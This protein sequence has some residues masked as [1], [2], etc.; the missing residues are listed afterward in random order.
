VRHVNGPR[1]SQSKRVRTPSDPGEWIAAKVR[2]GCRDERAGAQAQSNEIPNIANPSEAL[3]ST[4]SSIAYGEDFHLY[5]DLFDEEHVCL[6][7]EHVEFE[8]ARDAVTVKIPL[9]V[10]EFLRSYPGA[11]LSDA[12][13]TDDEI[14]REAAILVDERLA[15]CH[16]AGKDS[17]HALLQLGG[18]MVMG[19]IDLPRDQQVTNYVQY[20]RQLRERQR[21]VLA[22]IEGLKKF[23]PL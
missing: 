6:R 15:K 11:D 10:W 19:S 17:T 12:H 21:Q 14:D 1:S 9:H 23:N 7:L 3:M 8:A 2:R 4:K 22:R 20:H 16:A 18:A 13:K 5:Q